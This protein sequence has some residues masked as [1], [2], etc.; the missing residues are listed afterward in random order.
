MADESSQTFI[1][2][3]FEKYVFP[4]LLDWPTVTRVQGVQYRGDNTSLRCARVGVSVGRCSTIHF[5][6]L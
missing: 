5:H 1:I 2:G 6:I 3:I 4:V